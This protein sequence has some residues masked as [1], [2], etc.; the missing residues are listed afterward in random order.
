[1]SYVAAA[2]QRARVEVQVKHLSAQERALFDIAKDN[3]LSCWI[4]TNALRP[5]LRKSLNPDQILKSRWVLTWENIE[6]DG[7]QPASRKAKAR[8]VV[9]GYQDPQLTQVARDSPTL[10]K[11]GHSTILQY[12]ASKQWELTSFD[13]KT[14]FL[15]GKADEKNPL[16][17]EP[18]E[19]LR[20]K[21]N[22][23]ADKVCSLVGNAYGRVDAPLLFY[24]EL[25]KQLKNLGFRIHPLEPC[26]FLLESFKNDVRTLHGILGVHVDDGICGG[27]AYFHQQLET[28]SK[29]LPFGSFKKRKFTFTGIQLEQLP[30]FS[31]RASQEDYIHRIMAIDVGKPRR[32]QPESLTTESEKSKLRALVGSLQ[33]AVTHTRPDLASKLGEVQASMSQPK[34]STLMLCNKVLREAQENSHVQICFRSIPVEKVTHVSFGDASFASAK[35]LSSFQGSLICATTEDLNDNKEAPISPLNWSSKKISRVVRSTLSAEAYSMSRSVD[36]LGWLRP[37][38]GEFAA[39]NFPWQQPAKAYSCLPLYNRLPKSI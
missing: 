34:V 37:L 23:K 29:S 15:R 26:V 36:R 16:A 25:S 33:Y 21:L 30:D 7:D 1:M 10:T 35:Q 19:E 27:D 17:M 11:E 31:I 6:A 32:E 3:E 20:R 24:K 14:A 22:L 5:I 39:P 2:G 28:L 18:P 13:I 9:L 38:W 8:L 12:I 4:A